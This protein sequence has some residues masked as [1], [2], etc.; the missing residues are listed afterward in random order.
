[1]I[2]ID[3]ARAARYGLNV[4]DI[5]DVIET[6]LGG[7]AATQFGKASSASASRC[8]CKEAERSLTLCRNILVDTPDGAYI[9]LSEVADFRT[10][11]GSMNIAARTAGGCIA[12]GVFIRGR[13]MGSVVA[14][15]QE[16]VAEQR[17]SCRPAT[18]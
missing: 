16:R 3:R 17:A 2:E 13:D 1:M 10:V 9:P 8:G 11:G 18:P 14:D 7:Q 15:M 4:A 5:Q 6:A 12:I